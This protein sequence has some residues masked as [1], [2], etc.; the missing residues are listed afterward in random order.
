MPCADPQ[1]QTAA[2]LPAINA[3]LDTETICSTLLIFRFYLIR[4]KADYSGYLNLVSPSCFYA[5]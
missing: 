5:L 1:A 3:R 2:A 4:Q